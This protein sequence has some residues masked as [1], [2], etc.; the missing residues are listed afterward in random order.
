MSKLITLPRVKPFMKLD[1]RKLLVNTFF[2]AH[3][4][5]CPLVFMLHSHKL[6]NKI[7]KLHES[8]LGVT[9]EDHKALFGE[10]LEIH[11]SVSAHYKNLL[12][13]DIELYKVF[14]ASLQ[15]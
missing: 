4:N 1:Q 7:N 12:Y 10:L 2:N 14:V 11:N 13:L 6:N 8:C 15:I 3:F 9:Y 5:Y